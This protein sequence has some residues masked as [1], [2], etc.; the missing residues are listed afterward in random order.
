MTRTI[1]LLV[2]LFLPVL[3][4]AQSTEWDAPLRA[5][6]N[7]MADTLSSTLKPWTVPDR[8]FLA[9]EFG[10]VADGKTVNTL[11]I[12]KAIDACASAGGGVLVKGGPTSRAPSC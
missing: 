5:S 1:I 4:F 6:L 9:S 10:A 7:K 3:G 8:I 12:Q 11:A 2:Y